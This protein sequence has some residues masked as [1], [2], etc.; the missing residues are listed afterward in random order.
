MGEITKVLIVDDS[1][2]IRDILAN[3]LSCDPLIEIIGQAGNPF[4]AASIIKKDVPDVMT[5]DIEMPKMD[6]LTFLRKVMSQHPIPTVII[7]TLTEESSEVT[8]KALK[9]GAIDFFTK[10]SLKASEGLN[11]SAYDLIDKVKHAAK[12]KVSRLVPKSVKPRLIPKLASETL[13]FKKDSLVVIGASTGGT[14]ALLKVLKMLPF[15]FP[16]VA[17]VQHMP[18]VFTSQFAQR[19]DG[20][21]TMKVVEG[22]QSEMLETGKVV[23]APG[24]Y[25]LKLVEGEH[26]GVII[27]LNQEEKVNRHRPSVDALFNSTCN[28]NVKNVVAVLL[29]GM[30][31]DGAQGLL[32]IRKK[33]GQTIAQNE[34][35]CVVFGMPK[36]A[37][38]IDAASQVLSVDDIGSELINLLKE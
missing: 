11:D 5:L 31:K 7:S 18:K 26:S 9:C 38:D 21:C 29:T 23:I 32:S 1:K 34:S 13:N 30:G 37:I 33:W 10:S 14:E 22:S 2:L 36:A 4:E 3:I 16:K 28:L 17:V 27:D 20:E 35:S 19:L 15:N 12:V 24:D 8:L 25:H 6:G